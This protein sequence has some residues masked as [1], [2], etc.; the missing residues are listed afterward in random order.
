MCVIT[1]ARITLADFAD[2]ERDN[3][4]DIRDTD[5]QL[6]HNIPRDDSYVSIRGEN[7]LPMSRRG[8]LIIGERVF[9]ED[10]WIEELKKIVS[11]YH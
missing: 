5:V 11:S 3:R 10:V 9:T 7:L 4:V 6:G 2:P 8:N 1:Q